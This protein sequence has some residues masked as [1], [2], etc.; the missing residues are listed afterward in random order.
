MFKDP[1]IINATCTLSKEIEAILD[2]ASQKS[3]SKSFSESNQACTQTHDSTPSYANKGGRANDPI[4]RF[5]GREW[6][7]RQQ[8]FMIGS[9]W[10]DK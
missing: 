10:S 3:G 7:N 2:M 1:N 8:P 5:R 9:S 6:G 4:H